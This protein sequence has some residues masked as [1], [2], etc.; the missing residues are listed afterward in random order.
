MIQ[1]TC[2]KTIFD[3]TTS[4]WSRGLS[5][6]SRRPAPGVTQ[7]YELQG[8]IEESPRDRVYA[9]AIR[10]DIHLRYTTAHAYAR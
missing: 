8:S 3:A 5:A 4:R 1:K 2:Q 6:R 10:D 7:S 9:C